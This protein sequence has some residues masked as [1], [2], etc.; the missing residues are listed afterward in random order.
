MKKF[1]LLGGLLFLGV[2]L[3]FAHGEERNPIPF[4]MDMPESLMKAP[5]LNVESISEHLE[6][7][8]L[9]GKW[10]LLNFWATWCVPCVEELPDLNELAHQMDQ[11]RFAVVA[12][13]VKEPSSRV[14][15]F[16]AKHSMDQIH[17]ALDLKGDN[18]KAFGVS[19]FPTSFLL[20]Q[21]GNFVGQIRGVRPWSSDKSLAYFRKLIR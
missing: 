2:L 17:F 14:K 12:V 1:I 10:V 4:Q 6:L 16:L 13:D 20:D 7:P 8:N 21:D 3:G 11:D 9:E 15:R 5:D 19:Q 18:Y